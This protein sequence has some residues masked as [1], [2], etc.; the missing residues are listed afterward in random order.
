MND[1]ISTLG[2]KIIN[3]NAIAFLTSRVKQASS[4]AGGEALK[5][6]VIGFSAA[7]TIGQGSSMMPLS[8][9]MQGEE[10][11]NFLEQ[12]ESRGVSVESLRAKLA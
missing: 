2:G 9:V 3:I 6:L 7:A 4:E 12:L 11:E 1:F 5:Q 8:L 10:A